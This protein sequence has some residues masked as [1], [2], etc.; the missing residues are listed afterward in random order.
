MVSTTFGEEAL[1]K[2][3]H[4]PGESDSPLDPEDWG[5]LRVLAH[6]M[7]DGA[8]DEIQTIRERPVWRPVPAP[9]RALFGSGLP[10]N[11]EALDQIYA[12]YRRLIAP[13]DSGNRHPRFFG[14]VQGGGNVAGFL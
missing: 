13:Y 4:Q 1:A 8:L 11:G 3:A 6:Q 9:I 2:T 14:W 5:K 7:L 10:A 12:E